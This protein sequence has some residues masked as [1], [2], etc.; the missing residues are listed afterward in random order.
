MRTVFTFITIAK[1]PFKIVLY[2]NSRGL[3]K[4]FIAQ[5]NK[6]LRISWFE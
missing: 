4:P 1:W 5:L 6:V 3:A 2:D